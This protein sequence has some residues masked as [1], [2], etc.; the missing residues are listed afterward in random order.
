M[1]YISPAL[2]VLV[3]INDY[4]LWFLYNSYQQV[5][6]SDCKRFEIAV[7]NSHLKFSVT[8]YYPLKSGDQTIEL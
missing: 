5:Y 3:S 1:K 6:S 4:S 2:F 7:T 8:S